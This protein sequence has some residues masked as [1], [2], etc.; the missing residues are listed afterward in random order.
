[1]TSWRITLSFLIC[2]IAACGGDRP[3]VDIGATEPVALPEP[4]AVEV[5]GS[6]FVG[7]VTT[8]AS[9]VV[10]AEFEGRVEQLFVR[11]GQH[12][13]KGAPI[14]KLDDRQVRKQLAA[15]RAAEEAAR[16]EMGR[17]G[18]EIRAAKQQMRLERRLYRRGAVARQRIRQA[19][20]E[21]S[22][23]SASYGT[24]AAS[25]RKAVAE[26]QQL[27]QHLERSTLTAP[28]DGVISRIQVKEGELAR[29]GISVARVFDPRDLRLRFAVDQKDRN[30]IQRG[31][32]VV[33]EIPDLDA[34]FEAVIDNI[35][36]GLEPP[37]Q[38]VVVDAEIDDREIQADNIGVGVVG[39]VKLKAKGG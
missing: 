22:R 35:S 15:A 39:K 24:A 23:A 29:P 14:L 4:D 2:G 8:R 20:F 13:S 7:V 3:I 19:K 16:A 33:A 26:R 18:I 27:E 31:Q 34:R 10:A 1:M 28:I 21:R 32:V 6:E 38:F 36:A 5:D 11:A 37:L 9:V 25:Y 30:K 12:V 17:A